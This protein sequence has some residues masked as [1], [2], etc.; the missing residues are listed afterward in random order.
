[1]IGCKFEL[2]QEVRL[3]EM[4]QGVPA[5]AVGLI[6]KITECTH[7]DTEGTKYLIRMELRDPLVGRVPN[8]IEVFSKRVE[9]LTQEKTDVL[10]EVARISAL[11]GKRRSLPA[12]MLQMQEELG[13]LSTEVAI[14]TGTKRREPSLDGVLGEAVDVAIVALDMAML[15]A[16]GDVEK[17]VE[18]FKRKLAKWESYK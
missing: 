13:E 18:T 3:V 15:E 6:T 12:V 9:L 5:G 4:Y 8:Y 17:V 14:A 10:S 11:F 7:Y 2:G 16:G 1:M